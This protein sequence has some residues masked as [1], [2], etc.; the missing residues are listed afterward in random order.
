MGPP[1][2]G[3]RSYDILQGWQSATLTLLYVLIHLPPSI[4]CFP[5]S[6]LC[7]PSSVTMF[8]PSSAQHNLVCFPSLALC[9]SFVSSVFFLHQYCVFLRQ[10]SVFPSPILCYSSS[11]LFLPSSVL[12]FSSSVL[13]FS[14]SATVFIPSSGQHTCCTVYTVQL[15]K[16]ADGKVHHPDRKS[17]DSPDEQRRPRQ[18]S[19]KAVLWHPTRMSDFSINSF[20]MKGKNKIP[21]NIGKYIYISP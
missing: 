14:S 10:Y 5:S 19:E 6:V 1:V 17:Q 4:L 18:G 8:I 11:I 3:D 15:P 7:L 21:I 13:Y 9:F 20:P 12:Y 16:V 2:T